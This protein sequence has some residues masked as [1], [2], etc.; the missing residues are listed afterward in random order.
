MTVTILGGGVG[1]ARFARAVLSVVDAADV[2]I[3]V[4]TGDDTELHGLAISPDLDTVVYTLADAIDPTRGWGLDGETWVAMASLARYSETRPEPSTAGA[5]WFNLGD[6]DLATH[7]YRTA[8][9]GE[10][11]TLTTITSE[12]ARAWKIGARILPMSDDRFRTMVTLADPVVEIG[13]QDYFVRLRHDVPIRSVRFDH[14]GAE[15][16]PEVRSALAADTILIAPSNPI[17]SIGPIRALPG[18]DQLLAG[19]RDSVVAVSPIVGGAALKGPA[20]RMLTELGIEPSVG[21]IAE[22]YAP[23]ASTLVVD[24][25]DA[26]LA[27]AVERAG[28]RCVTIPSVM[29]TP[30]VAAD[31]ARSCLAAAVGSSDRQRH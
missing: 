23:V 19:R 20:D 30:A 4:N 15:P 16:T 14:H 2:T 24:P 28:M 5:T 7:L 1:A 13:F 17:V 11:A 12:I 21:G 8:R 29:S 25:V 3:V 27:D 26:H 18:V 22:L 6:R 10:G 31:L 9:R